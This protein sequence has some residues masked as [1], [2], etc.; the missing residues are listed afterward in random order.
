MGREKWENM[1][2]PL[3]P[4]ENHFDEGKMHIEVVSFVACSL[5]LTMPYCNKMRSCDLSK[6][7]EGHGM[8]G[9]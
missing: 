3:H 6:K 1:F 9:G 7:Y 2:K 5:G 4:I 8:H